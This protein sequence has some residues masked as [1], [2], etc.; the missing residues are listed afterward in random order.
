MFRTLILLILLILPIL[1]LTSC[2][3]D[4]SIKLDPTTTDLVV[5]ADIETDYTR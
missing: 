2:E 5:N 4:I 3:K 1:V